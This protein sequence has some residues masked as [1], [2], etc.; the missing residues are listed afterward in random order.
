MVMASTQLALDSQRSLTWAWFC[1]CFYSLGSQFVFLFHVPHVTHSPNGSSNG[2]CCSLHMYLCPEFL[3]SGWA[4]FCC[5]FF[6]F[7]F[8]NLLLLKDVCCAVLCCVVWDFFHFFFFSSFQSS[9]LLAHPHAQP[10][11]QP[12]KNRKF[13]NLE[14][15]LASLCKQANE[16][17]LNWTL[18]WWITMLHYCFAVLV[19]QP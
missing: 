15:I 11:P 12:Y 18:D 6:F 16:N 4:F 8:L 9:N 3:L 13:F 17:G 2:C 1:F 19:S 14:K 7:S 5:W 10:Q